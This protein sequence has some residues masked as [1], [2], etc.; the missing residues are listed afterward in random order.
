[1]FRALVQQL[2]GREG[3]VA[4]PRAASPRPCLP[5][6]DTPAGDSCHSPGP[7]PARQPPPPLDRDTHCLTLTFFS[8]SSR[9][10]LCCSA[11]ARVALW[12]RW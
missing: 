2:W 3:S 6:L 1:M 10:L 8:I 5:L 9:T 11:M 12:T 7:R 4:K